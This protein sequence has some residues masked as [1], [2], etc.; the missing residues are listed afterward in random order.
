M[1]SFDWSARVVV[2]TGGSAGLNARGAGADSRS[3]PSR[4]A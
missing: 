1:S 4:W 3:L 2:L